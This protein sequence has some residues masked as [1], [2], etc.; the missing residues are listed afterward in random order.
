MCNGWFLLRILNLFL[1]RILNLRIFWNKNI[2]KYK[3]LETD[4]G[5]CI[6]DGLTAAFLVGYFIQQRQA[7]QEL[8]TIAS[9]CDG[10]TSLHN[11]HPK[12]WKYL[13]ENWAEKEILV[14]PISISLYQSRHDLKHVYDSTIF[15]DF[16]AC[17]AFCSRSGLLLHYCGAWGKLQQPLTAPYFPD[18]IGWIQQKCK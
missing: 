12:Y 7:F 1:L 11:S 15:T 9:V 13:N 4:W 3:K 16:L 6:S 8:I 5:Y 14:L 10:N 2:S 17:A 18:N